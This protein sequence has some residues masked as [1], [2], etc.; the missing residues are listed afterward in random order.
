MQGDTE[1][2]GKA[3][4]LLESVPGW[5]W[6]A[7]AVLLVVGGAAVAVWLFRRRKKASLPAPNKA[8]S[9]AK[10]SLLDLWNGFLDRQPRAARHYPV[11][12]VLGGACAGKTH[13]IDARIDLK[14]QAAQF[15]KSVE[16]SDLMQLYPG[17]ELLVQEILAPLLRDTSDDARAALTALW[18]A[19]RWQAPTVVMALDARKLLEDRP[20]ELRELGQLTR[21]KLDILS[22]VRGKRVPVRLCLTHLD[23]IEGYHELVKVLRD[24]GAARPLPLGDGASSAGLHRGL[25]SLDA[26][27]PGAVALL[28]KEEFD[29]FIGFFARATD[30]LGALSAFTAGLDEDVGL[31][32]DSLYLSALDPEEHLGDPFVVDPRTLAALA[33]DARQ[34]EWRLRTVCLA[35][36]VFSATAMAGFYGYHGYRLGEASDAV[37]RL[38]R[39]AA[40][41]PR[42]TAGDDLTE[43]E[44]AAGEQLAELFRSEAIWPLLRYSF[45]DDKQQLRKRF[46]DAVRTAY[47]LPLLGGRLDRDR[48]VYAVG[49]LYAARD[50]DLGALVRRVGGETF[51]ER[52][53]VPGPVPEDYVENS[54]RA[55]SKVAQA[56]P[57]TPV[58]PRSPSTDLDVWFDYLADLNGA[59]ARDELTLS[60][61]KDLQQRAVP[62]ADVLDASTWYPTVRSI[63]ELLSRDWRLDLDAMFGPL[64][65]AP[66]APPWVNDNHD[67]LA[68]LL[69]MVQNARLRPTRVDG[70]SLQELLTLLAPQ[71]APAAPAA[72]SATAAAASSVPAAPA[73]P[74]AAS[75]AAAA[76][77][78]A[79]PASGSAPAAS[80]PAPA[81]RTYRLTINE[82]TFTFSAGGWSSLIGHSQMA[83]L[84][85]AFTA[86][87]ARKGRWPFFSAQAGYADVGRAAVPG[88]GASGAIEGVYT[89]E[90]F[91]ADVKPSLEAVDAALAAAPL[92]SAKKESFRVYL[93]DQTRSYAGRLEREL[94]GY[95]RSFQLT[96]RS[97]AVLQIAI[98]DMSLPSSWFTGFLATFADNASL[99]TE[100]KTAGAYLAPFSDDLAAFRPVVDIMTPQKG[101]YPKLDAYTEILAPL[102]DTA[103]AASAAGASGA[104]L[105]DNLSPLGKA[106]LGM[107]LAD[108][109]SVLVQVQAWLD[110]NG[111]A[112]EDA[113]PFLSPVHAAYR[114]GLAEINQAVARA[115][116][117][118]VLGPAGPVLSRFPFDRSAGQDAAVADVEALFLPG[119]GQFWE[120]FDR[121]IAPVCV[122]RDDGWAARSSPLGSPALPEGMLGQVNALEAM[123][124]ALWSKEGK[125]QPLALSV[126]P[127]PLPVGTFDGKS[128]TMA[129]LRTGEAS[130]FAFNQMASVQPLS[131][132][133]WDQRSSWIGIQLTSPDGKTRDQST[134]TYD[135]TWSFY[136]LLQRASSFKYGVATWPVPLDDAGRATTPISFELSPD[137]WASVATAQQPAPAKPSSRAQRGGGG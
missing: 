3:E 100:S 135:S 23:A 57:S 108:K 15:R 95:Y 2:A 17:K 79:P 55:W 44:R 110:A 75:A 112:G 28:S 12:I 53:G 34:A 10:D 68:G 21:G 63:L 64:A 36:L 96:V 60:Q 27:L 78:A 31:A 129:Y 86:D 5:V 66:T 134:A 107:L 88:R 8:P 84:V 51:A 118:D 4:S 127:R 38:V 18:G 39:A 111:V 9:L 67:T 24:R 136:R 58:D 54:E 97:Q 101:Q 131:I 77:S 123:A 130:S 92:S 65:A 133:W 25:A 48:L 56:V 80:A 11:F 33:A 74:A 82:Q 45:T 49:L 126:R 20:D 41:G 26:Y 16:Q 7:L 99:D 81:D 87:V 120:A 47:L 43:A 103:P 69:A 91:N 116:Q 37:D 89:K 19:I 94:R 52:I 132:A 72:A 124:R 106:A 62:L 59:Y 137:P 117:H 109:D 122:Q 35:V 93:R 104:G 102:A 73:A 121:L 76:S 14:K 115:W 83:L 125:R 50:N 42:A 128:V 30:L 119:K 71:A 22:D 85:D 90:A 1:A 40:Q 114:F 105:A 61:L 46:V 6:A 29:R 13:L 113:A 70:I 98:G 32:N